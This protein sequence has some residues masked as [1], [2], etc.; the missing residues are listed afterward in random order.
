MRKKLSAFL[1]YILALAILFYILPLRIRDT[2]SGM[3]I[4]LL[5]IPF[6]TFLCSVIYGIRQGFQPLLA[7]VT[8]IL[9]APTIFIFYNESAWIYIV[10]YAVITLVGNGIGGAFYKKEK[11]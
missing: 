8:A 1:P 7:L 11:R 6:L 5:V 4:M 10:I 3:L 2:G 9:F